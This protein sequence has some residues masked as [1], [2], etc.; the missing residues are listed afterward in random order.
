MMEQKN[1]MS[2]QQQL[3]AMGRVLGYMLKDYKFSFFMVVVCILGSALATLR[4]TLFMQSLIDDY[5]VPLTRAQ[6]PDCSALAGA[7]LSVAVTYGIG[8]LCAYAYNRIMVNISQGTMRHLREELFQHMESL[9]IRYFDTH[10]HGDIMSVYTNDVDTLRQ[11]MSQSIPQ[12]INS[13]VTI[14]TS[15]VSMLILDVPLTIITL[16]IIGVMVFTTSKI[17]AKSSVYFARKKIW[18][19]STAISRK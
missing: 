7:L 15:F 11:L 12:V 16:A 8:I 2:L 13:S 19:G 1:K 5:I 10:A 4:G 9:P 14:V 3:R 17:A 6:T 18:A